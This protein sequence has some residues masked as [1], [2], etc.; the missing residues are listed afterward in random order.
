MSMAEAMREALTAYASRRQSKRRILSLAGIGRS[1][2]S[3]VAERVEELLTEGFRLRRLRPR[4]TSLRSGR[5]V[6]GK[7]HG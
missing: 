7:A 5:G 1:G 2:R 6:G 4:E 3:D